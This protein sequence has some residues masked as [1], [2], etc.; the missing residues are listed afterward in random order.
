ML[1]FGD[2]PGDRCGESVALS[3]DGSILAVG[4]NGNNQSTG[5]VMLFGIDRT[6]LKLTTLGKAIP[7]E[8]VGDN[9]GWSVSLSADGNTL[10]I[11]SV[12]NSDNGDKAGHA[13][14]FSIDQMSLC[15]H[16]VE[17][18][19]AQLKTG[20]GKPF[21]CI[22]SAGSSNYIFSCDMLGQR[23]CCGDICG[24]RRFTGSVATDGLLEWEQGC[25]SYSSSRADL[26]GKTLCHKAYYSG[27]QI[28]SCNSSI[29]SSSCSSCG[30]CDNFYG[31]PDCTNID[32]FRFMKFECDDIDT[33]TELVDLSLRCEYG[34]LG[35]IPG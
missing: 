30:V 34:T 9:A 3:D 8:K 7:G 16:I 23:I 4:A 11:G 35:N 14:V 20:Y 27:D 25:I 22:C 5:K 10:A 21:S 29:N 17:I 31:V 12:W 13:R 2:A 18:L 1:I 33:S 6:A 28:S 15:S 24:T 32:G 26:D 19:E